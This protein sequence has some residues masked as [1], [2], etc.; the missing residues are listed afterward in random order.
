MPQDAFDSYMTPI[1][2]KEGGGTFTNDPT[3][4]GGAT[5][6]GITETTAR[7]FGYTGMMQSMTRDQAMAIYRSR[8]WQQ[9]MLDKMAVVSERLAVLMLDLGIN[10]G[11]GVPGKFVQRV[12]NV[13]NQNGSAWPDVTVDGVAGAMTR[14]AVAALIR[15]RG[16]EGIRVLMAAVQA[17][18][19]VR[20]IELA[21]GDSTQERF[22]Y[23]WLSQRAF[24]A[25]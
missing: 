8:F 12:L 16:S 6:W 13:L 20:Y 10:C 15:A 18:A 3:D 25:V 4:H 21:E 2:A 5:I 17:Q 7:A 24:P 11:S 23:G 9:P 1:L 22:E 14:A 19:G